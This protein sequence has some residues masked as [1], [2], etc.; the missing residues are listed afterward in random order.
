MMPDL[1]YLHLAH[2]TGQHR[3][4]G[5]TRIAREQRTE[6]A[7][8]HQQHQGCL[9]HVESPPRPGRVGVKHGEGHRVDHHPHA[10]PP[11][12]PVRTGG[13]NPLQQRQVGGITGG[14][15]RLDDTCHRKLAQYRRCT[16]DVIGMGM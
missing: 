1:E 9:V 13:S 16:A 6:P 7:V 3:L 11:G 15:C 4:S 2:R 10:P 12:R 14:E 5:E 8:L